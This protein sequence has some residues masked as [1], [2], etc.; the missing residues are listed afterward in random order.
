MNFIEQTIGFRVSIACKFSF[1]IVSLWVLGSCSPSNNNS[2]TSTRKDSAADLDQEIDPSTNDEQNQPQVDPQFI[3]RPKVSRFSLD[4]QKFNVVRLAVGLQSFVGSQTPVLSYKLPRDADYV[5]I[6]RCEHNTILSGGVNPISLADLELSGLSEFEKGQLYRSSDYFKIA[7]DSNSCELVSDGHLGEAFL[8][9][10]S[11][12]GDHR[13]LVRSCV[14]PTRL[15][16]RDKLSGRNCS[17]RVAIS[18]ELTHTNTRKDKELEALRLSNIF[19]AKIDSTTSAMLALAEAINVEIEECYER[20]RQ[21]VIDKKIRDAWITIA[22]A[23]IEVGIEIVTVDPGDLNKLRY[24][25]SLKGGKGGWGIQSTVDKL[26]I[27][28]AVQGFL[29]ADTFQKILGSSHDMIRTCARY[30]RLEKEYGIMEYQLLDYGFQYQ[31]WLAVA[32]LARAGQLV[33]DGVPIDIPVVEDSREYTPPP[34][35]TDDEEE[36]PDGEANPEDDEE[37]PEDEV[38]EPDADESEEA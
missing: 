16:D 5:E 21:R 36:N 1:L 37:S 10:F 27:L 22:S 38:G 14:T 15:E 13:Y 8:D 28:G 20:N 26:Q 11:P 2:S 33:V 18:D 24:Y 6:L 29:L 25:L 9:S 12:S 4:D 35:S 7:E 32:N 19:A 3:P 31:L 23:V 34:V 30:E 17:R